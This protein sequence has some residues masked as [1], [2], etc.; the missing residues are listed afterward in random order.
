MRTLLALSLLASMVALP[1]AWAHGAPAPDA[2]HTRLLA[3]WL[4]DCG[5]DGGAATGACKGSHDLLALD[6][7]EVRDDALGDAVAFRLFLDKGQPGPRR[8]TLTVN[9]PGGAR[10]FTF[11]TSDDRTFTSG[12]GFDRVE[13][14]F[15]VPGEATR[16]MVDGLVRLSALG[17]VGDSISAF[18]VEAFAD[19][20]VGDHMPGG[21]RNAVGDCIVTGPKEDYTRQSYALRGPGYYARITTPGHADVPAGTEAFVSLEVKNLLSIPQQVTLTAQPPPGLA[22][23]FHAPASGYM[24]VL[25]VDLG[26]QGSTTV[27]LALTGEAGVEG[28]VLLAL[29][30]DQGGYQETELHILVGAPAQ[31]TS[32]PTPH[33]SRASPA[34]A[35]AGLAVL[36]LLAGRRS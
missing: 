21:C 16:L 31:A 32:P 8:D 20:S 29:S 22:A 12:G 36:A 17:K 9:T 25:E 28:D 15:P 1:A 11:Q 18:K 6:V 5:G 19:G 13:G 34:P 4:D 30:T 24:D 14:P 7:R 23:R 33:T 10:S 2:R 35:W 27:H 26:S 3:D